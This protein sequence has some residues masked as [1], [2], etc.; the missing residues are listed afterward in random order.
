M[1]FGNHPTNNMID[2]IKTLADVEIEGVKENTIYCGNC[3]EIMRHMKD[4]SVDLVLTSPPFKEEDMPKDYWEEYDR[5]FKEM[6]RLSSKV[7]III[8][9]ATKLNELIKKYPPKRLMIWGKGFSQYSYR[10]NPILVYQITENYKVNKYIWSDC[11]GVPSVQGKGKEHKYQ[12]PLILYE[13]LIKM[14]KNCDL[15]L[16]PFLGSGTTAVAA[17]Q[18]KRNFI[19][20]EISPEY[21]EISRQRLRQDIL[22]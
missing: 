4:H 18:L 9:S 22:L 10:F 13:L 15:V 20:V 11:F 6:K 21:C 1:Y 12:D 5:W 19:G 8:H 2:K 14:F 16:D 17:K 7:L 3:L